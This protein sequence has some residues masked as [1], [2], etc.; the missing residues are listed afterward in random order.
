MEITTEIKKG[1]KTLN[2]CNI[3]DSPKEIGFLPLF[4][5]TDRR[6]FRGL[7]EANLPPE[8]KKDLTLGLC[9]I[10]FGKKEAGS[11]A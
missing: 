7:W 1:H 8:Q 4:S 5:D 3:S 11:F 2:N 6:L 9:G 10:I